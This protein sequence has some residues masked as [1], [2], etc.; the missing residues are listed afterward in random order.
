MGGDTEVGEES[1]R[2]RGKEGM[3]EHGGKV[4]KGRRGW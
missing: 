2:E 4:G 3:R 1:G